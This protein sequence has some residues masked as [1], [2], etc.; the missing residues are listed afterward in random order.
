MKHL[1]RTTKKLPQEILKKKSKSRV[2]YTYITFKNSV[3]KHQICPTKVN[4]TWYVQYPQLGKS[5]GTVISFQVHQPQ[6]KNLSFHLE[7]YQLWGHQHPGSERMRTTIK[8][9]GTFRYHMIIS[10]K[11][12]D[13]QLYQGRLS[14]QILKIEVPTANSSFI[15][16]L[17]IIKRIY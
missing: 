10:R 7:Y 14:L 1:I 6:I 4:D 3:L 17:R 11:K 12:K 2:C 15:F 13:R 16:I 5:F 9:C 8:F